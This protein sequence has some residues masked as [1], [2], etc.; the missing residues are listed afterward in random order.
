M[1]NYQQFRENPALLVEGAQSALIFAYNYF[2]GDKLTEVKKGPPRIAMYARL[3]D[4]H[5]YLRVKSENIL[6]KLRIHSPEIR[7]RVFVDSG[8]FLEKALATKRSQNSIIFLCR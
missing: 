2:A 4:Y 6:K 1:E 3:R 7:S 5:K 8:P